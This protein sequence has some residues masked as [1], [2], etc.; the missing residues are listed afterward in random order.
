MW[1]PKRFY[2]SA[3]TGESQDGFT[4]LLDGRPVKT[5]VGAVLSVST[6]VLAAAIASEWEAQEEEIEPDT[7]PAQQLA[8]SAIDGVRK[9]RD[10][11]IGKILAYAGTDLLCYRAAEPDDLVDRQHAAWQ[12]LL[13]WVRG[14]T[15]AQFTVTRG[16][17]PVS[18]SPGVAATLRKTVEVFDDFEIAVLSSVTAAAGSIVVALALMNGRIGG[19]EAFAASQL[20]ESYQIEK[21]GADD[22]AFARRDKLHSDILAAERFLQLHRG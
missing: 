19:E 4:V 12:P 8:V 22:E 13:D 9:N 16:V 1:T 15:G 7:M 3:E 14:E 2:K 18:Q 11:I 20:D 5:P 17:M 10:A 21:W 6:Q